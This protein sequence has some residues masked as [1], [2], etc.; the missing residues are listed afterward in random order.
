MSTLRAGVGRTDITPPVGIAHVNW[1]ARVHDRAEGIDLDL[2]ATVLVVL[3]DA[4]GTG[5]AIVD[6]DAGGFQVDEALELRKIVA[7]ATGLPVSSVRL[8]YTHTHS[9]PP[10]T[11]S[12]GFGG[13]KDLPGAELVPAYQDYVRAQ[14]AGAARQAMLSPRRCRIAGGYGKS[15]VTVNR[16]LKGP[17]GSVLVGE[18]HGGYVDQTVVVVRI[19]DLE[20]RPIAS[21]VGYGT[22]PITLAHQNRLISPDYPGTTKRVVEELTGAPSLFLQGCAGDQMPLQGL[23]GDVS[24]PR[25]IGTRLGAEAA[26]VLLGLRTRSI[27]RRFDRVVESGA[28]LG[29]WA[30]DDGP[31]VAVKLA[32]ATRTARLPVRNYGSAT[33]ASAEAE[34]TAKAMVALDKAKASPQEISDTNARSKRA[35]MNAHWAKL[36]QGQTHMEV[37]LHGIRLGPVGLVG[38]PLEP[39]ARIGARIR[40]AAPLPVVQ[41]AGYTNGWQ[42]YVP[43]ADAYAEGGYETEWATPYAPTA[44]EVLEREALALLKT[45]AA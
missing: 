10:W 11:I 40:D 44:A 23:T 24:I 28:P 22:H 6:L 8:S 21:I 17:N 27:E 3:D 36:T 26:K 2:W 30:E 19:D 14:I 39:F 20:E 34:R 29:L 18:N 9:G 7:A 35:A 25:R 31:E 41:F 33:D 43:V 13:N 42:G 1:G 16:R 15:D 38:A 45:L 5:A 12:G 37:E 32:V 4:S